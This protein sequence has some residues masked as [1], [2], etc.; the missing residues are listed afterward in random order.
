MGLLVGIPVAVAGAALLIG[1]AVG[2]FKF[3]GSVARTISAAAAAAGIA[4]WVIILFVTP[5]FQES[6]DTPEPGESGTIAV[7]DYGSLN[8]R[9]NAEG[10]TVEQGY[11]VVLIQP[12]FSVN[13]KRVNASG[14]DIQVYEYADET[15]MNE[16]AGDVSP[17]GFSIGTSMVSW[18]DTPHFYKTG[19]IIVIY[20]GGDADIIRILE[21][22]V[23]PQFAGR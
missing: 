2:Y 12:F 15:A 22:I 7:S 6:Q 5:V 18:I 23:G 13:G 1:G 19:R 11:Q 3:K 21:D 20:I 10:V 17:D 14:H 9:L 8:D 4:I 16:D